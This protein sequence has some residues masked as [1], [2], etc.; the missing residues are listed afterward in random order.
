ML[1]I[2]TH[3]KVPIKEDVNNC[4]FIMEVPVT[5]AAVERDTYRVE[6]TSHVMVSQQNYKLL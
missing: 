5:V 1:K 6:I 2:K 3:V 4:V